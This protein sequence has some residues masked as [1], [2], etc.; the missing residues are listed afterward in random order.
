MHTSLTNEMNKTPDRFSA[1]TTSWLSWWGIRRTV[2]RDIWIIWI[3]ESDIVAPISPKARS[4]KKIW[5]W[6]MD[7]R[8]Y[9]PIDKFKFK[10][11]HL[12][13]NQVRASAGRFS[14]LT[15]TQ[16]LV[17]KSSFHV[18]LWVIG[19]SLHIYTKPTPHHVGPSH[20][21]QFKAHDFIEHSF[22]I[23]IKL[24]IN[25]LTFRIRINPDLIR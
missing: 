5:P 25:G 14:T 2:C 23:V 22:C 12:H 7:Q 17:S 18:S 3:P 4:H 10:S 8:L 1:I 15:S 19:Q 20:P 21:Y 13:P 24:G 9:H 6:H 11:I 16:A